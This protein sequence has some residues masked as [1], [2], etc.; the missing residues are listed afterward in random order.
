MTQVSDVGLK[1]KANQIDSN[2]ERVRVELE[3]DYSRWQHASAAIMSV[4]QQWIFSDVGLR[5]RLRTTEVD[6]HIT[7]DFLKAPK[8]LNELRIELKADSRQCVVGRPLPLTPRVDGA[9]GRIELKP[10]RLGKADYY[11]DW[12]GKL[13]SPNGWWFRSSSGLDKR[14]NPESLDEVLGELLLVGGDQPDAPAFEAAMSLPDG[15]HRQRGQ[16]RS[17]QRDQA[18]QVIHRVDFAFIENSELRTIA[19][20]DWDECQRAFRSKCWK[21]V[22]ILAGGIVETVVLSMLCSRMEQVSKTKAASNAPSD[23]SRWELGLLVKAALELKILPPIV[24]MLP[25]PLRKYRNLAH[26][27]NE[28][29]ENLKFGEPEASTAFHAVRSILSR[30]SGSDIA[31]PEENADTEGSHASSQIEDKWIDTEHL[32]RSGVTERLKAEGYQV[33]LDSAN[34]ESRLVDLEGWEHV[35]LEQNGKRFRLKFHD[36]PAVGGY[37]VLLRRRM[38]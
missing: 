27:G 9:F 22:L 28:V 3:R 37:M 8:Q 30:V 33:Q 24:E 13:D 1:D 2:N 34:N 17:A 11:L 25:E 38:R 31:E 6:R 26:P 18:D 21:S 36:H 32:K 23:L 10:S 29:R 14:L 15:R 4:I 12:D 20:R 7:D 35:I 5:D 19:E 16:E